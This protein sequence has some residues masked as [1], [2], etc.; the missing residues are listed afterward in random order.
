MSAATRAAAIRAEYC[1]P[2]QSR[3]AAI[4]ALREKDVVSVERHVEREGRGERGGSGA[5]ASGVD[6]GS[7]V[8]LFMEAA[9]DFRDAGDSISSRLYGFT[10][11][12][13]L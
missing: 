7:R 6:V 12:N 11:Y 1:A 5:R 8:G 9:A 3:D 2:V 4:Q 13:T 10:Y